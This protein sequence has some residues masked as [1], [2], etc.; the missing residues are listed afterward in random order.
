[1]MKTQSSSRK[2]F[3]L[4]E[5]IATLVLLGITAVFAGMLLTTAVGIFI[6]N[7]EGAEDSQKVQV[8]MNRLIKELTW[9]EEGT[10]SIPDSNTVRWVSSHPAPSRETQQTLQRD[11]AELNLNGS[12]LMDGLATFNATS[13]GVSVTLSLSTTRA[14]GSLQTVTIYP[15]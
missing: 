9:V 5:I 4:I 7:K 12:P 3:T 6:Q 10:L 14:P 13:D 15:R 1:M 8:A 2:G 11:G